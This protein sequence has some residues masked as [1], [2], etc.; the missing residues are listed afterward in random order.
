MKRVF[1]SFLVLLIFAGFPAYAQ[2]MA[3]YAGNWEG[4]LDVG[5]IQLRI[6]FH[7]K[8]DGKGGL[9]TTADSP[10]QSAYGL[11]CDSTFVQENGLTIRMT[12]LN[13]S[14]SGKLINDSTID[15]TFVQQA[16]IPLLLKKTEQV[17]EIKRPQ[18]PMAP[19]PYKIEEVEYSNA[20]QSLRYGATITI[21]EGNSVFP[22]IVLITGSGAQDRDETIMGHKL[23]AVIADHLSRKGFIVLRVDD[24]GVG[25]SSGIF[26]NATSEDFSKDVSSHVDYL[27]SRPETNKKKIGL[28]G[29]S[30]GGMIAPMVA[31]KR[32]DIHFI[33]LLAAPGVPII[34]LMAAQNEAIAKS[35]GVGAAALKEIK[36]LF[37]KVVTAI[38]EA[39]DSTAAITSVTAIT[40]NWAAAQNKELLKE[41]NFETPRERSDYITEMVSQFQSPWFRYFIRFNPGEYLEELKCKVL[42]LNGDKDIQVLA[43][44]NLPGIETALK[45]S[46]SPLYNVEELPGLNHLM[47]T[48]KKC[49][50]DEYGA[51]EE[52]ISPVALEAI[53][54]WLIKNVK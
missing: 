37:K 40:E 4:T 19:F 6:I 28:I 10:D 49:S 41:L 31:T 50:L 14:F 39:P 20:D 17:K 1:L 7:I 38:M 13:A 12:N 47:Q 24:R 5:V 53:S 23:F 45:K 42:A 3:K 11:K 32:K 29:H 35:S 52:T 30:E 54:N 36:P 26:N 9:V 21:P 44:Q 8:E 43:A 51:L 15:G 33:L 25:K 48:C 18:T 16:D 46:K 27:L 34:D 22:A 2:S